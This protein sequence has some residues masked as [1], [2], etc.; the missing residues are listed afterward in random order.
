MF[1]FLVCGD[2]DFLINFDGLIYFSLPIY[3][4]NIS[5]KD[6]STDLLR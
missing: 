1:G 2:W 3:F 4:G 5:S 6:F